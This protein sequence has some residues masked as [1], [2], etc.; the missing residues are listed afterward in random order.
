MG[1]EERSWA[2]A[3]GQH[4]NVWP[5]FNCR[6]IMKC[7]CLTHHWG[8]VAH[9]ARSKWD[10]RKKHSPESD[11]I[12]CNK[13]YSNATTVMDFVDMCS[14]IF[15]GQISWLNMTVTRLSS[16]HVKG[17]QVYWATTKCD[18]IKK[19]WAA[20]MKVVQLASIWS[21]NVVKVSNIYLKCVT[22]CCMCQTLH[23]M[24]FCKQCELSKLAESLY[25]CVKP[26]L[27]SP[28]VRILTLL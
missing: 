10:L 13:Y 2:S 1:C 15:L 11:I 3:F 5:K 22:Y 18:G 23:H 14:K 16:S 21:L 4:I 7:T 17:L 25:S 6:L 20:V 9:T 28:S 19:V 12:K 24:T 26:L 27:P 8:G